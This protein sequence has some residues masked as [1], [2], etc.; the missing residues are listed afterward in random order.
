MLRMPVP[1][2]ATEEGSGTT[3]VTRVREPN[4][5]TGPFVVF[6]KTNS[7]G[8]LNVGLHWRLNEQI[9]DPA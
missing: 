8:M 7:V 4:C 2:R 1:S 5:A 3:G 6:A 9:A